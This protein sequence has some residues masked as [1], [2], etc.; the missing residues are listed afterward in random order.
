MPI[1]LHQKNRDEILRFA[2]ERTYNV[3]GAIESEK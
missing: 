1:D 2:L 3:I